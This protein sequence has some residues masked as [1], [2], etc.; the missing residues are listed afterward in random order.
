MCDFH[1][2]GEDIEDIHSAEHNKYLLIGRGVINI[3]TYY[4][5]RV[6][7]YKKSAL[8]DLVEFSC[9]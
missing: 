2:E 1:A 4:Y 6:Y 3:Y 9:L 7:I 8:L 5:V